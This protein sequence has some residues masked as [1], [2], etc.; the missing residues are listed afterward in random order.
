MLF[1]HFVPQELYSEERKKKKNDARMSETSN[2][3]N[4]HE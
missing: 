1:T 3:S 4:H 2:I